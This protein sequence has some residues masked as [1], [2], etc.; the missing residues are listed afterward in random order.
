MSLLE[1]ER[2]VSAATAPSPFDWRR[3]GLAVA[4][5]RVDEAGI[6]VEEI[7]QGLQ[8]PVGGGGPDVPPRS[9]G[10]QGLDGLA[11]GAVDGGGVGE[12]DVLTYVR[13]GQGSFATAAPDQ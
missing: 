12:L 6:G 5:P 1:E 2:P 10:Q 8:A 4:A 13:R 9:E 7:A 11:L 3:L